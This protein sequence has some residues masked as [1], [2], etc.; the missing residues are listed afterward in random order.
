MCGRVKT[1]TSG[2]YQRWWRL[3]PKLAHPQ[4][5]TARYEWTQSPQHCQ[6]QALGA[7]PHTVDTDRPPV[8]TERVSTAPGRDWIAEMPS[9]KR[10]AH[11]SLWSQNGEIRTTKACALVG[12]VASGSSASIPSS[13]SIERENIET[14]G[15]KSTR[16]DDSLRHTRKLVQHCYEK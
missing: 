4:V 11:S 9:V 5:Y 6:P 16:R 13:A 7:Q 15:Y 3:Q 2:H 12:S 8:A 1:T 14:V 10:L